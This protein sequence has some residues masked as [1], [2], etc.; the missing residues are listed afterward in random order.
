MAC[1]A[2]TMSPS[3]AASARISMRCVLAVI[4]ITSTPSR[5]TVFV[6]HFLGR[7]NNVA[8]IGRPLTVITMSGP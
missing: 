5:R 4:T 1:A 3:V 2:C 7:M 6:R 8:V